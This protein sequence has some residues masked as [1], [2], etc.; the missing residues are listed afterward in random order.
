MPTLKQLLTSSSYL[1]SVRASLRVKSGISAIL[2]R[3]RGVK[4]GNSIKKGVK[5]NP[6]CYRV[7]IYEVLLIK[8]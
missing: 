6:F 7:E 8:I 2:N 3:D 1:R 5:I 4:N